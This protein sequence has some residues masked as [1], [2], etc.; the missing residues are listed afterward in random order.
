ME[1]VGA[2]G[3]LM[4]LGLAAGVRLYATILAIGLGIRFGLF[5]LNPS[6]SHLEVLSNHWVLV[7]AGIAY[8]L[9]FF[10]DKIPW[11]DSLW[12]GI[13]TLIRPIGAALIGSTALGQ[14]DPG[15][16]MLA[17]LLV[18]GVA[19]AGHSTKAGTRL[20]VNHSPEPF[21]NI[22]LSFIEDGLVIAGAWLS[23]T[24]PLIMLGVVLAFLVLFCWLSPKL[25]R[26]L[27]LE[28]TAFST[29]LFPTTERSKVPA[30]YQSRIGRCSLVLRAAAGPGVRGLKNSVGWLVVTDA[31]LTF[32]TRRLFR[33]RRY[34]IPFNAIRDVRFDRRTLLT[35]LRITTD[36]GPQTFDLFKEKAGAIDDLMTVLERARGSIPAVNVRS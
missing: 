32:A 4:G 12:D 18:G 13:H 20:A 25:F 11:V 35:Q 1:T 22:I 14:A 5:Q 33:F 2:I 15:M 17:G 19:L 3:S 26:L 36:S 9:E 28:W 21:S 30:E 23:L 31:G 8:L 7:A 27:R 34:D 16:K 6:L 29:W 24:H 10:A